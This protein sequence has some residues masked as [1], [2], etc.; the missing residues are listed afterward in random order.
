MLYAEM[1]RANQRLVSYKCVQG[2]DVGL[3]V[4]GTVTLEAAFVGLPLVVGYKAGWMTGLIV[5]WK[6]RVRYVSIPN[7][8]LDK[9]AIPELLF[10]D[11]TAEKVGEAL[12]YESVNI[13]A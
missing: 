12:R 6:A 3:A 5:K 2:S 8:I 4:S 1:L 9:E 13:G 11:C 10:G 7:I